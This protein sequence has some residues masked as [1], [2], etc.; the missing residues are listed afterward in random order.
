M[1]ARRLRRLRAPRVDAQRLQLRG[2]PVLVAVAQRHDR[3]A[4][5]VAQAAR[6]A[7]LFVGNRGGN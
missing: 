1:L 3:E 7:A 2:A 5:L 6:D 4:E